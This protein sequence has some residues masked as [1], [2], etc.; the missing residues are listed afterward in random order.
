MNTIKI[1]FVKTHKDIHIHGDKTATRNYNKVV[2][3]KRGYYKC[4]QFFSF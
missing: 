3:F 4:S 1:Q 2:T